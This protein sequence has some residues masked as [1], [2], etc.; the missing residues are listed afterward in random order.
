[1]TLASNTLHSQVYTICSVSVASSILYLCY[2]KSRW[3]TAMLTVSNTSSLLI[4]LRLTKILPFSNE[5]KLNYK[6]INSRSQWPRGLRRRAAAAR[7][8]GLQVR[9]PPGAWMSLC[10]EWCVLSPLRTDPS[11]RGVLPSV[12]VCH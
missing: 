10:R 7:Y 11:S 12:Y 4:W 2:T 9:I 6:E 8:L 5:G 1:M 3:R